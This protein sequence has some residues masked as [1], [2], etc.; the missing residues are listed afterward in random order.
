MKAL[1][2]ALTFNILYLVMTLIA[3]VSYWG[4]LPLL[5]I[6]LGGVLVHGLLWAEYRG[7]RAR[8]EE[9]TT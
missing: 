3:W 4:W 5:L 1:I 8:G 9:T 7:L 6:A 2:A